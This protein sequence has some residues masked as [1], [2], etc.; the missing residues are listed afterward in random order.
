MFTTFILRRPDATDDFFDAPWFRMP[1]L[2]EN[3][4]RYAEKIRQQ[5]AKDA[6]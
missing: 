5:A 4:F 1:T 6:Q 3:P 2:L